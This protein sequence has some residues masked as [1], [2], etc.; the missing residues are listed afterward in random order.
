MDCNLQCKSQRWLGSPAWFC[1]D[2]LLK[3]SYGLHA[4]YVQKPQRLQHPL[5][6]C[7]KFDSPTTI[8]VKAHNTKKVFILDRV[9]SLSFIPVSVQTLCYQQF[10]AGFLL[11]TDMTM[12][13]V[14][15]FYQPWIFLS[16]NCIKV[17]PHLSLT[18][19]VNETLCM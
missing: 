10:V 6:L 18:E 17:M 16:F 7:F 12:H 9:A 5:L 11:N 15:G 8:M 2:P 14:S 13:T 4:T 1:Y 3:R 19:N